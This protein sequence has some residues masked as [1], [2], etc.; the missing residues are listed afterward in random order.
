MNKVWK[1]KL[2]GVSKFLSTAF[3]LGMSAYSMLFGGASVFA[4]SNK[5][6]VEVDNGVAV[7]IV[8]KTGETAISS[9]DMELL[10]SPRGAFTSDFFDVEVS[11]SN[12]AGYSLYM[13][14]DYQSG[15]PVAHTTDLVNIEDPTHT[16]P[17][18]VTEDVPKT[19][20]A[21]PGG[22]YVNRWGWSKDGI[23]FD[24]VPVYDTDV[25][26][27]TTR[28]ET[29]K[30]LTPIHVGVNANSDMVSGT[31]RN[32]LVFSAVG[33][34][35][36]TEYTLYF[37]PGTEDEVTN[38]PETMTE[39]DSG[40]SHT[41]TVPASPVPTRPG[42]TFAGYTDGEDTYWPSDEFTVYGD[43]GFVGTATLMAQWR[44]D[45]STPYRICYRTNEPSGEVSGTMDNQSIVYM[46]SS[47]SAGE[48]DATVISGTTS[49]LTLFPPNWT[50]DGYG[51][52]GWNTKAD[53][54]G[55][56]YGPNET[57][58]LTSEQKTQLASSGLPIYAQWV[59]SA[60]NMSGWTGCSSL[61]SGTV[62]ALK[63]ENETY[64][65]AKLAD[66]RCWTIEN[67]RTNSDDAGQYLTQF[68]SNVHDKQYNLTNVIGTDGATPILSG[69]NEYM[70]KLYGGYYSWASVINS[71]E[72]YSTYHGNPS[73]TTQTTQ[74]LCPA[75]WH[76]PRS[77]Y[78]NTQQ[79]DHAEF[80]YLNYVLNGSYTATGTAAGS[81][82][83]RKYPNNFVFSGIWYGPAKNTGNSSRQRGTYGYYWSSTVQKQQY[84]LYMY[85]FSDT[86]NP[87]YYGALA[88]GKYV[89]R[90]L[91]CV[92]DY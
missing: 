29:N 6:S 72:S 89:G 77:W 92:A 66:G 35:I 37:D 75:G 61:A 57:I 71:T 88:L 45:C 60:G 82:N 86:I 76:V 30:D 73:T 31:Y 28:T 13:S 36:P 54:T 42:F 23:R 14:S 84:A 21:T 38:L 80:S 18:L 65:V 91:R 74:G 26:I 15:S 25:Q 64:A 90:S 41:F 22:A 2:L 40:S 3:C 55:T 19:D 52:K 24:P 1:S 81:N 56:W 43:E 47:T 62:T 87:S 63:Y 16:I 79:S 10:I 53:G 12:P 8:D 59:A 33:N 70:W 67:L 7:R 44:S 58:T 39:S 11:T 46:T 51:F 5:L 9:L 17:S 69:T 50:L 32:N 48:V 83:W 49:Q 85:L 20:F 4:N 78:D 27:K 34:P 68:S